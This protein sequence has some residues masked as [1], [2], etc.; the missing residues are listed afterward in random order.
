MRVFEQG[1][2]R[3]ADIAAALAAGSPADDP[4][5]EAVVQDILQQVK[6]RGDDALLE[7]GRRFDSPDLDAISVPADAG[8]EAW[9]RISEQL[10]DALQRAADN[11]RRFHEEEK[12]QSWFS[13]RGG[14]MLGQIV[15]PIDSVGIYVP[16]GRA[17]YPS[18][19]L[20]TAMPASVA[21]VGSIAIAT[22]SGEGGQVSDSVLAACHL[23]GVTRIYR[24]GGAQ[25]IAAFAYGTASVARVDKVVGPGNQYVNAAKRLVFGHVGIDSLAG[26]SEVLIIADE[27]A[28]PDWVAADLI[29]QAEHGG[30]SKSI[31]ITW[32][33]GLADRVLSAVSRQLASEPRADLIR[34]SLSSM[35]AVVVARDADEAV[36]LSN[37]SAPEHLQI[38]AREPAQFITRLRN[39]GAIFV[40]PYT[41]VPLG[42]YVAGPS[43]TLPTGASARFCSALGVAEFQ[44]RSSLLWYRPEEYSDEAPAAMY[45][46]ETEGLWA[47]KKALQ[48]RLEDGA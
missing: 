45:L 9:E 28:N 6:Q 41:P 42:D 3:D 1:I 13:S 44:K 48:M 8:A 4:A 25:A 27:S 11:I 35:G 20:M 26:P 43:H 5:V 7:L 30:E 36:R 37:I 23:A 38:L 14:S 15:T 22:P 2:D 47:H 46:A 33:R 17:Q 18:T 19:V 31:L 40:G 10:R 29:A 12:Q 39:A 24:M 16:G 34:R 32:S 21:G